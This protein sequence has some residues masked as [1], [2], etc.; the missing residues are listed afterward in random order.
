MWVMNDYV[1]LY[2]LDAEKIKAIK[3]ITV[4]YVIASDNDIYHALAECKY[5]NIKLRKIT[6]EQYCTITRT[7]NKYP[8]QIIEYF[9]INGI[10]KTKE[11][12]YYNNKKRDN[13]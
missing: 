3:D 10:D 4:Y 12:L 1:V 5:R 6:Y 7:L 9:L 2:R 8:K 13:K 11:L